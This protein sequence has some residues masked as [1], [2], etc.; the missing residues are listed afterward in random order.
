VLPALDPS[1]IVSPDPMGEAVQHETFMRLALEEAAKALQRG[2]VPVGAVLARGEEVVGRGFN[3]PIQTVDPTGHAEIVALRTGARSL[4]NY[5]L[6]GTRL[7][8]TLEPCLMCVGA[9]LNAR[10]STLIYGAPEPKWGSVRSLL[11]I[12]SL[13]TNHRVQV[14]AGVLEEE[15]R[16]IVVDF[17]K[18]RRERG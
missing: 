12:D 1:D 3:Q 14:V 5:R 6:T 18:I 9:V 11:D 17:F 4:A 15:C 7:Y 8:V 13:A 10:V 16:R 2:E